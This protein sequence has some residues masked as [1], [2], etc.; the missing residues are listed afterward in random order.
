MRTFPVCFATM[1]KDNQLGVAFVRVIQFQLGHHR[2]VG[3]TCNLNR[4]TPLVFCCT[5]FPHRRFDSVVAIRVNSPRC[6]YA[7]R[8]RADQVTFQNGIFKVRTPKTDEAKPEEIKVK[9][10]SESLWAAKSRNATLGKGP[11]FSIGRRRRLHEG[12]KIIGQANW[13]ETFA[14]ESPA[15]SGHR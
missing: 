10:G 1:Q 12:W 11:L 15:A 8:P 7:S 5:S 2:K 6:S 3:C 13:R 14:L 9:L 4:L